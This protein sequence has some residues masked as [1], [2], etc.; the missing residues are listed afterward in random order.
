MTSPRRNRRDRATRANHDRRVDDV[1]FPVTLA[2][3]NVTGQRESSER[4]HR[5]VVRAPDA[6]LE[7]AAAPDG[8]L[9]IARDSLDALCLRMTAN[10]PELHVDYSARFHRNRVTRIFRRTD[11]LE[12]GARGQ[13]PALTDKAVN[14]GEQ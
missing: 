14:L 11:R 12:V 10:A 5:D 13:N 3:R 7:H 1:F 8:D 2:R 6:R 9:V 4:R